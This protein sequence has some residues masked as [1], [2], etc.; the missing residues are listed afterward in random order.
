MLTDN[1]LSL[2][3]KYQSEIS[4][5]DEVLDSVGNVKPH[6]KNLF[7]T[8]EQVG[9][10]ELNS[11][12]AEIVRKLRENGVSYNVYDSSDGQNRQWQLDPIPFL[13]TDTEWS[14][15]EKGLIQRATVL[16][17]IL[18]DL[19]GPR[20]LIKDKIIPPELVFGN[21]GFFRQCND[22]KLKSDHQLIIYAADMARGPDGRMWI[23]DNRTQAPSGSGYALENRSV[24]SR[25]LPELSKGLYIN[26]LSPY[27]FNLQ[28]SIY[29]LGDS[30]KEEP[31]AV[32][33]TPGP[34]NETYFEHSYLASYLGCNLVQGDDL[35]VRDG[36]VWL[37]SIEGLKRVD[38]IIRRVDD[39]FIDPLELREDS[40]LGVPGLLQVIRQGNVSVINPPG[41]SLL[42]NNALMSFMGAASK[43][44]IGEKLLLPSVATW[45]CGQKKELNFVLENLDKL[46]IKK[47]N[48]KQKYR[49]VYGRKLTEAES[50]EL[51][52]EILASPSDFVAQEEVSLSTTP[53]FTGSAI[54]P[55]YAALRSFLVSDGDN[56]YVMKG[57]L[58]RSSPEKDRFIVSNQYG[59]VSKDTWIVSAEPDQS[60]TLPAIGFSQRRNSVL[61]SRSA[62]NLF[63]AGRY[64]E[65]TL[66]VSRVI[67]NLINSLNIHN[68]F[69]T[70]PKGDHVDVLLKSITHL[71]LTYPGFV[72]KKFEKG[73]KDYYLELSS[74]ISDKDKPGSIVFNVS[75]FT[76]AV[77]AVREKWTIGTWRIVDLIE[78]VQ[79]KLRLSDKNVFEE[80]KFLEKLNTRL[81]TFY[82]IVNETMSR[83]S[84][85]LLFESGKLIER[86]MSLISQLRSCVCLKYDES[87]EHE[88]LEAV[89]YNNHSLISY[90][91]KYKSEVKVEPFLDMILFES[92]LPHSL[93]NQID[94]LGECVNALPNVAQT[95]R[96]NE[97]QKNI[98]HAQSL[99][100]LANVAQ[101]AAFNKDTLEREDLDM[102]LSEVADKIYKA[103][104]ELGNMY[105]S[106][107]KPMKSFSESQVDQMLNE[108]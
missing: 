5:Y 25:M 98:L 81:F 60:T 36:F 23:L 19:Y 105:F 33:L 55:R 14:E 17:L 95:Q 38:V 64:C 39:E 18:K 82:G 47:A 87:I 72:E 12:T 57:G 80:Q 71:T 97:A 78:N 104:N 31:F 63:W 37:K 15:I 88:I 51:R 52:N 68:N 35:L 70:I 85:M 103:S 90:R 75:C 50:A 30:S 62:E 91:S 8:I 66:I 92:K 73:L 61:S 79:R 29:K 7:E 11:R 58:T 59:G 42:E 26:K 24:L 46:I 76:S 84:G 48:R 9:F 83:D 21:T 16:N 89:L 93:V 107:I 53:S 102:L 43:Y 41:T 6:W 100:K 4:T 94:R 56:Y 65:R 86:T 27:F 101:L 99:V 54:E 22:V 108:I 28:K 45:W 96:L 32:Y 34:L 20:K 1:K 2:L 77:F 13:L 40:R 10:K 44:L 3:K 49:S 74:L 69:G 67:I 106:H